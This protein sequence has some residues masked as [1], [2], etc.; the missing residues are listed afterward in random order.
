MYQ[1]ILVPLDG[2]DVAECA[3][4]HMQTI[5]SGCNVADVVLLRVVGPLP[6]PGEYVIAESDRTRLESEHLSA[7]QSYLEKTTKR[8]AE[9]VLSVDVDVVE[10]DAAEA[11]V[12][13][14][15]RKGVDLIVM[16]T[17]GR[18]GISRWALGSVAEKVV[19]HAEVP[20]LLVRATKDAC[21]A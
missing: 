8:L 14:A 19:R 13:Y 21:A 9:G 20:V 5:V 15:G 17:H 4:S 12:D 10:G 7:A 16:A 6:L 18:S 3:L 2:S 1:K 11:I